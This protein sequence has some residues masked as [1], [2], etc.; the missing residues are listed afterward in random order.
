MNVASLPCLVPLVLFAI[1]G[2]ARADGP[3]R[4]KTDVDRSPRLYSSADG[5]YSVRILPKPDPPKTGEEP[6]Y[7]TRMIVFQ[8][9]ADG[10]DKVV[11]ETVLNILPQEALVSKRGDVILVGYHA[12]LGESSPMMGMRIF[13]KTGK[14]KGEAP[15]VQI[16]EGL[17][18]AERNLAW[19][20]MHQARGASFQYDWYNHDFLVLPVSPSRT[21]RIALDSGAVVQ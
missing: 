17:A 18:G 21:V 19:E 4:C 20:A 8:P 5:R 12:P 2:S 3:E 6:A 9:G 15:Y 10:T 13:D 14:L 11:S 7:A 1:A 16:L